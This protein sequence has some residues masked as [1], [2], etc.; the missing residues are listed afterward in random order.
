MKLTTG[1]IA[2]F[3]IAIVI[4]GGLIGKDRLDILSNSESY[5]ATVVE[6]NWRKSRY[7]SN[8][9]SRTFR[10]GSFYQPI[11][12]SKEGYR[13]AGRFSVARKSICEKL[14]GHEVTILVNKDRP[15]EA[16]IHSFFQFWLAPFGLLGGFLFIVACLFRA[17]KTA[18][19]IFFSFFVISGV[20]FAAEFKL[21]Q[22]PLVFTNEKSVDPKL[23]LETCINA[24]MRTENIDQPSALKALA[25]K[26]RGI[27]DLSHLNALTSLEELDLGLNEIDDLKPLSALTKLRILIVDGNRGLTSLEGIEGLRE[28]E[29][30]KLHCAGLTNI[31]AVKGMKSLRHLDVSCNELSDL[32]AIT[33]LSLLEKLNIDDNRAL[34]NIEPAAKKPN[35]ET[36]TMNRTA[37]SDLSPLMANENLRSINLGGSGEFSCKQVETLRARLVKGGRIRG[38]KSCF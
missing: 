26:K 37:I 27:T 18:V 7:R 4:F 22:D 30:L 1:L 9:G 10:S 35:L 14:I 8:S 32:S 5:N 3:V 6:C 34:T 20:N 21:F 24:A 2:I 16:R 31:D 33:E 19:G 15:D 29:V 17:T 38:P 23:A 11:A 13:A 12:V 36:I 25:C 28:L